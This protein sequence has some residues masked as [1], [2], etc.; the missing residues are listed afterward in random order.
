M[1][2]LLI[3]LSVILS[4]IQQLNNRR[5][6]SEMKLGIIFWDEPHLYKHC[7]DGILRRCLPENEVSIIAILLPMEGTLV[8][9]KLKLRFYK[10]VSSGQLSSE[11][12]MILLGHVMLVRGQ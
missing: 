2:T 3:S 9:Q 11:M 4:L 1:L 7:D 6:S 12:F 10:P 8:Q 5:K